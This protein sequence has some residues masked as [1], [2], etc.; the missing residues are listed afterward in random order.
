MEQTDAPPPIGTPASIDVPAPR[1]ST[2]TDARSGPA[3]VAARGISTRSRVLVIALSA[4]AGFLLT[5]V[6]S[7]PFV[8]QTIGD[9]V[10]DT[11]LG[12]HA[13]G[14]PISGVVAGVAFAFVSGLAGTF[15]ACN[16]AAFGALAPLVGQNTTIR[17]RLR[18]ALTPLSR[19][20]LGMVAVSATYGVI[21]SLAGT[22]M[23]QFQAQ[24]GT[25]WSPRLTQAMVVFGVVGVTMLYLGLAALDLVPDPFARVSVRFPY[26]RMAF[27]GTLIGAF[28]IGR[29]F[30][31][32]R[33][34]FQDAADSHNPLYGAAA[35]SLQSLGNIVILSGLFLIMTLVAGGRV[36]RWIAAEPRRASFLVAAAFITA[37]VFTVLYWDVRLLSNRDLIWYPL[38]PWV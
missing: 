32:F 20:A 14:T 34:L 13:K 17:G 28:L 22:H 31:L 3:A 21:V 18:Q 6:W 1:S 7:A 38:A 33:Q 35:F 11:L 30:P 24:S 4:L 15:T 5:V 10:A 27:T 12:H 23:P 19:L 25:G 2:V 29:P 37:G 8:D 26:A 16:V 36:G 9:N